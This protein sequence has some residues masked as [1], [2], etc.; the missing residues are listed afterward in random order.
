MVWRVLILA[1]TL[2]LA[3]LSSAPEDWK[4]VSLVLALAVV[5]F[6][7]DGLVVWT[8]RL[9]VSAGS[10]AQ[11]P[12]MALLGPAPAVA[13]GVLSTLLESRIY[14]LRLSAVLTNVTSAAVTGLV[15]GVLFEALGGRL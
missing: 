5:M 4:P 12:I 7:A 8:R 11:V 13:I 1:A 10:M 14:R 15:G 2:A 3:A 9:R 6:V